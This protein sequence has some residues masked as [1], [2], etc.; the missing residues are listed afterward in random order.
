MKIIVT[1]GAGF[2]ASHIVDEYIAAGHRVVIIDNLLKGFSKNLNPK[3]KFYKAD[4]TDLAMIEK[5][6]KAE[7][8]EIVNHHA[9]IAEVVLSVRDPIPTLTTNVL[10]T[11]NLLLAFG[12]HG[13]GASRRKFIFSSTGG[14]MYGDPKKVPVDET[15]VQDPLSPY[16]LSK[17]LAEETIKFYA[18]QFGFDYY[19]FRYA[20][21]FGPRQNPHGEAGI[22]AIFGE[23][24]KSGKRPTI[25][26]DG[27]KSRDYVYVGDV[28]SANLAA[29]TKGKNVT[30]NIGRGVLTTDKEMFDVIAH[31][32][33]FTEKP[34]YAPYRPGEIYRI[35][36]DASKA[37]KLLGWKPK[38]TL[39]E[40]VRKAVEGI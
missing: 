11:A 36:L 28:A 17:Q 13:R 27:K 34:I 8:P 22:V 24:M 2:I 1:G 15:A 30:T 39:E 18:K 3:A 32:C 16:G 29:L 20:N 21:V 12:H 7:K 5:I 4:I 25:F 19:I 9:A 14:A 26:G 31:A 23:L 40:G 6:F 33:N 38:M 37:R 35:S 10:G